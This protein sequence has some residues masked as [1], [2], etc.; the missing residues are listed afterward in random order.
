LKQELNEKF[1]TIKMM[2]KKSKVPAGNCN[3]NFNRCILFPYTQ[4]L[5]K[6]ARVKIKK[7][8]PIVKAG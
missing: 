7:I 4:V 3:E 8:Q 2:V 1:L 6:I 5:G